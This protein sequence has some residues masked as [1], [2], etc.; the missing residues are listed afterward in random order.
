MK[1]VTTPKFNKILVINISYIMANF[2]K[3]FKTHSFEISV[4]LSRPL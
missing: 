1:V 3:N 4:N 2:Y